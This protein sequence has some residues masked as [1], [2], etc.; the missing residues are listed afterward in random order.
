MIQLNSARHGIL[1]DVVIDLEPGLQADK[2]SAKTVAKSIVEHIAEALD[3]TAP[4][5]GYRASIA[6]ANEQ[7]LDGK[8]IIDE[9]GSLVLEEA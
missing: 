2:L 4:D 3:L 8:L 6:W 1:F 7:M 5:M 9:D